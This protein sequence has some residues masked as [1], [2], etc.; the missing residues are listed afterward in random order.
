MAYELTWE[1]CI[2]CSVIAGVYKY[3][4]MRMHSTFFDMNVTREDRIKSYMSNFSGI[5]ICNGL[6]HRF[7]NMFSADVLHE[8]QWIRILVDLNVPY[9]SGANKSRGPD[10]HLGIGL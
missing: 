2:L 6:M 4:G 5:T 10:F 9:M 3:F 1:D 7:G 8:I